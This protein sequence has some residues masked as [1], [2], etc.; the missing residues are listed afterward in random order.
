MLQILM[1]RTDV[2]V[3]YSLDA[4]V[5]LNNVVYW[6]QKNQ[7]EGKHFHDGRY[8]MSAS[9][10]GLAAL[11]PLWS[12]PQIKRLIAKLRDSGALLVGDFNEDRMNRTN[13]YSPSDEILALYEAEKDCA[14]MGRNR[15]MQGTK[16]SGGGTKSENVNK[17]EGESK[18]DIPPYPPQGG[19]RA[20]PGNGTS[21]SRLG[22]LSG[23]RRSGRTTGPMAGERTARE[24][25]RHGTSSSQMMALLTPWPAP[26]RSKSVRR[27][28]GGESGFPTPRPG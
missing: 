1:C 6:T 10:K 4:A 15:K 16:P 18:G 26:S 17:E 8:W 5:L 13:W 25:P 2:A 19:R 27:S 3:R 23:S 20:R 9:L 11:Y 22:S 7:S 21:L 14:P 24:R 28:G 12:V